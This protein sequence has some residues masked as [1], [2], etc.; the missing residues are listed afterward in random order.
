MLVATTT[1][2][3]RQSTNNATSSTVR[4]SFHRQIR[5][6]T[7]SDSRH[8]PLL[9][10]HPSSVLCRCSTTTHPLIQQPYITQN[11]THS[12]SV[13]QQ[14]LCKAHDTSPYFAAYSLTSSTVSSSSLSGWN[15]TPAA[16]RCP[17]PAAFS[18]YPSIPIQ[19]YAPLQH[20]TATAVQ[21]PYKHQHASPLPTYSHSP[22]LPSRPLPPPLVTSAEVPRHELSLIRE[23]TTAVGL[24]ASAASSSVHC[25]TSYGA[26]R[27]LISPV[28]PRRN[29]SKSS[30]TL[31]FFRTLL[32]PS[33]IMPS[34]SSTSRQTRS[35]TS[36]PHQSSLL[37]GCSATAY[38]SIRLS[39]ISPTIAHAPT[40]IQ[41]QSYTQ[42]L[43]DALS[44]WG[45]PN[46]PPSS[47][48]LSGLYKTPRTCHRHELSNM[49]SQTETFCLMNSR[50]AF[51]SG[52]KLGKLS[53]PKAWKYSG[54]HP[55]KVHSPK[56]EWYVNAETEFL[57]DRDLVPDGYVNGLQ[58]DDL[59]LLKPEI[60]QCL[61]LKCASRKQ[62]SNYRKR[63]LRRK[64]QRRPFDTGSPAVQIGCLTETILH[65]RAHIMRNPRDQPM[66]RMMAIL[67]S[68]RARNMKYLYRTDFDL[69]K[70]VCK[71]LKIKCVMFAIP[72]S[73]DRARVCAAEDRTATT[74]H[75]M[76]HL[77]VSVYMLFVLNTLLLWS[78]SVLSSISQRLIVLSVCH[79]LPTVQFCTN[80]CRL[81]YLRSRARLC[82]CL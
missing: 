82:V 66:K 38:P 71:E 62:V 31:R 68:R 36:V 46:T 21:Q 64:L 73:R 57:N 6:L 27:F 52:G 56:T 61:H 17:A 72:D 55:V 30:I 24:C 26:P 79:Y 11:H 51:G 76:H 49:C 40:V 16:F 19:S 4:H 9:Y 13:I 54:V 78:I 65:L 14:Q 35:L 39:Y 81:L 50:R 5:H 59:C 43:S 77:F 42:M 23:T 25:L 3:V 29:S 15:S 80:N 37:C 60:R 70:R 44:P 22:T 63:E 41:P 32:H 47:S 18:V 53:P 69:Y 74:C 75:Y 20:T 28:I 8:P 1:K 7:P 10:P 67:L 2:L 58:A 48:S 34:S 33:F 45:L 12:T